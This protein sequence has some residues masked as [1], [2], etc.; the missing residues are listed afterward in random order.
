MLVTAF[1][2]ILHE[3]SISFWVASEIQG[4]QGVCEEW[5]EVWEELGSQYTRVWLAKGSGLGLGL[6]L[7]CWGFKGVQEEKPALFKSGQW[8]LH[9]DSASV[10]NCILV[11]DLFDQDGHQH[12]SSTV[13]MVQTLLPVTFGYS[14]RSEAVVMRQLRG[15]K[16]LWR[17]SL[18]R[19]KKRT[20][21]GPSKSCWNGT[22]A[23][24]AG[25]HY[26]EGGLEFHVCSIN[27][28]AHTKKVWKLI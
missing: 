23:F 7:V 28:S 26:S 19:W 10:H 1:W 14:L 9:R 4:R 20:Y 22:S 12:S 27:K 2:H 13:P 8:H 24:A 6:A 5:W 3:S 21:M 25:G 11:R 18:T 15:W 16:R 17:S